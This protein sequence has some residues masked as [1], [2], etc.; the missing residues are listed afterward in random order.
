DDHERHAE[1]N[2][3]GA[4]HDRYAAG[5]L[6][7][8]G[9]P[10]RRNGSRDPDRGENVAERGRPPGELRVTVG[11]EAEA[12]QQAKGQQG[13]ALEPLTDAQRESPPEASSTSVGPTRSGPGGSSSAGRPRRFTQNVGYPNHLAPAASHPPNAAKAISS[14]RKPSTLGPSA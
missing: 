5:E 10:R 6:E 8:R 9:H 12:D 11:G 1:R 2:D 4:E 14:R 13:P 7:E 3:G